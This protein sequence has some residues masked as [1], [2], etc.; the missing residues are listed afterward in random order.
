MF[1]HCFHSVEFSITFPTYTLISFWTLGGEALKIY[2]EGKGVDSG[3]TS[4]V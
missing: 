1:P 3:A 2:W 4:V